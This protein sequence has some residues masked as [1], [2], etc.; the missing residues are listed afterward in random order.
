MPSSMCLL[1]AP[2]VVPYNENYI[3][4]L[5]LQVSSEMILLDEPTDIGGEKHNIKIG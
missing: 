2:A 3:M 5:S 4:P 1:V